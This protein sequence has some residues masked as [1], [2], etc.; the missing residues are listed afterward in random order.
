MQHENLMTH[1]HM[2]TQ[3]LL[4]EQVGSFLERRTDLLSQRGQDSESLHN[5]DTF[6]RRFYTGFLAERHARSIELNSEE[7]KEANTIIADLFGSK[8][9]LVSCMDGRMPLTAMFGFP[10]QAVRAMRLPGGDLGGFERDLENGALVPDPEALFTKLV[11]RQQDNGSSTRYQ[12]LNAHVGCAARG[13]T[14]SNFGMYPPDQGLHAD[15]ASKNEIGTAIKMYYNMTPLLY[16]TDPNT[17]YGYM[18]LGRDDMLNTNEYY[19]HDTL[20]KLTEKGEIISTAE[21]ASRFE[22]AFTKIT[23]PTWSVNWEHAYSSTSLHLWKN[24]DSLAKGPVLEAIQQNVR[25]IYDDTQKYDDEEVRVRSLLLLTD[26][27]LGWLYARQGGHPYTEHKESCVVVDFKNKG[28]FAEYTAFVVAPIHDTLDDNVALAQ[29]IVRVNR[30]ASKVTDTSGIY[31]TESFASAPVPVVVKCEVPFN[32]GHPILETLKTIDL[33]EIQNTWIHD[34]GAFL[35]CIRTQMG[36]LPY[37]QVEDTIETLGELWENLKDIYNGRG[38]QTLADRGGIAVLPV[39]VSEDR[40]P[41][42]ILQ[43]VA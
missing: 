13:R 34:K 16:V 6:L 35:N 19:D 38:T 24:I 42:T 30:Q 28:P 10:M 27:Y 29:S 12:V 20:Q 33:H 43:L 18:G 40:M 15:I 37:A 21:L 41:Q 23:D 1:E 31:D 32:S 36:H 14:E 25:T 39:L 22:D 26:A 17:G 2:T 4:Q 5:Q 11:L 9:G 3:E 7:I 8:L